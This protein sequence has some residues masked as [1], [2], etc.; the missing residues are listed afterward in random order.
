MMEIFQQ[1]PESEDEIRSHESEN[2]KS[3]ERMR[4]R[5]GLCEDDNRSEESENEKRSCKSGV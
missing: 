3:A 2:K 4:T 5:R 1:S